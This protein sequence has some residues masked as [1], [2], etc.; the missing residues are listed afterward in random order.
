MGELPEMTWVHEELDE[1][2]PEAPGDVNGLPRI[3][4]LP[5][6]AIGNGD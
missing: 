6:Y 5:L 4:E 1:E 2:G 3:P